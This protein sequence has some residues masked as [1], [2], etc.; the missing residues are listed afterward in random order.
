MEDPVVVPADTMKYS[1]RQLVDRLET[2]QNIRPRNSRTNLYRQ[3][4]VELLTAL[5]QK[6]I[7]NGDLRRVS[8]M[9]DYLL[10]CVTENRIPHRSYLEDVSNFS[11][12]QRLISLH[13]QATH[14]VE[15]NLSAAVEIHTKEIAATRSNGWG[16]PLAPSPR[17]PRQLEDATGY[18]LKPD[19]LTAETP[20]GLVDQMRQFRIWSGDL[21]LREL[22]RRGNGA[23]AL[24]TLSKVLSGTALPPLDLLQHFIRA[25]GGSVDDVQRWSTAWRQIR[26]GDTRTQRIHSVSSVA[27]L[28]RSRNTG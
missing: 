21:A 12:S 18:D 23:F 7:V 28:P 2:I 11:S 25:C 17:I 26:M 9:T 8:Q 20:I 3:I 4:A 24:S 13:R 27:A 14:D 22:V 6:R 16:Q 19:P 1:P 10:T 5:G 15:T